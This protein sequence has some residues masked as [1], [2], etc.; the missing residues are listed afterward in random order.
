MI[1]CVVFDFDGT[2]VKSNEIKRRVFYE[3]TED[4]VDAV[5][6]LDELFSVPDSGDRYNIF[7]LLIKNLK[8]VQEVG[9]T[10]SYLSSLYTKICEHRISEAPEV[11]GAFNAL[12]E[13]KKIKVKMFVSS[14]TPT[15]TLQRIIG[16]RGWSE[17]FDGIMGSPDSKED[18]LKS[19]L[20]SNNYSLSEVVYIGDS[21]VD[22]KAALLIG[23]K[24]I[25]IGKNWNRFD[26][27]PLVLL[28]TL[29]KL[30]KELKL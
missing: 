19:I 1:K 25:G 26:S 14:A 5:P 12:T 16:M 21:E 11:C 6:V 3:V 9:V 2:L 27:R 18:H 8:L 13:L 28:D 24:F 4:I 17:L 30:I 23:C 22:Q 7:D 20:F 29:E 15:N 10:A